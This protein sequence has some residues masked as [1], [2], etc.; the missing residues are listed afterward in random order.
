MRL[1]EHLQAMFEGNIRHMNYAE[2]KPKQTIII[3]Y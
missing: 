2:M 3:V 1:E